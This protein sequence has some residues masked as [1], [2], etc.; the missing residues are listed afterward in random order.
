MLHLCLNQRKLEQNYS[1]V[2]CRTL[3]F[4]PMSPTLFMH[5]K[6][7]TRYLASELKSPEIRSEFKSLFDFDLPDRPHPILIVTVV[8][9]TPY[10][11]HNILS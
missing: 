8:S 4:L 7:A 3:F 6:Y 9:R 5:V 1:K 11:W 10:D 2:N